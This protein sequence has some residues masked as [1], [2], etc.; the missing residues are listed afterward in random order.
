MVAALISRIVAGCHRHGIWVA[1]VAIVATLLMGWQTARNLRVTTDTTAIISPDLDWRRQEAEVRD[2]F[3]QKNGLVLI[4]VDGATPELAEDAA[5]RLTERLGQRPD[6]F[7]TVRRPDGGDFFKRNG[8]LYLPVDQLKATAKQV[9]AAQPLIGALAADPSLR[10]LFDVLSDALR[11][12]AEGQIEVTGFDKPLTGI[13][14]AIESTLAGKPR[15]VS[16]Q[17]LITGREPNWRELRRF[18][19]AQPRRDFSQLEPGKAAIDYIRT[20]IAELN[21]TQ[22]HGITVRLSGEVPIADEEFATVAEGTNVAL[23]ASLVLV[24]AL[25]F[26]A[27]RSWRLIVPILIT[28]LVGLVATACFAA[29]AIGSLNV[30]SVSFA[31]LFVGIGVDFGIQFAVRFRHQ[32]YLEPDVAT[33]MREA[34]RGVGPALILAAVATAVGFFSFIPTDYRG[35]SELGL[36][37][38]VGM[39]I[40]A[41]L[42]LTLLP[43]LF[44][45]FRPPPE[46]E[47]V[48]FAWAAPIDRFLARRRL[49]VAGVA[50]ILA[51]ACLASLPLI[52]FDMN[53]LNLKDPNAESVATLRELAAN[54][55]RKSVV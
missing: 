40:A 30:I 26:L 22:E 19:L 20:G 8:L 34:G 1:L 25:L 55:D 54:P 53:P 3:P 48:G 28:L 51:V 49:A 38:G 42:N 43:A 2:R 52:R 5:S 4:V 39:G 32:H 12:V 14:D 36:I 31:V 37:S 35:V 29:T 11:G 9:I 44:G 27:L 21:L 6:I 17:T 13:A 10:G 16:W 23:K 50:A 24:A 15:P 47:S 33:A 46:R 45:L 7:F 18:I 41:L